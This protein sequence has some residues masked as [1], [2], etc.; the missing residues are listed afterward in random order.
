MQILTVVFALGLQEMLGG[1]FGL[2]VIAWS[3]W[4]ANKWVLK[5]ERES[6][7]LSARLRREEMHRK[8]WKNW[9]KHF[10]V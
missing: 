6:R 7:R 5:P 1:A 8:H 9:Q 4:L 10:D 2:G 3:V